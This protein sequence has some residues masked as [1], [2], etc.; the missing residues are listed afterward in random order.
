V[1]KFAGALLTVVLVMG[2]TSRGVDKIN[3]VKNIG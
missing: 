1:I 2:L 3:P